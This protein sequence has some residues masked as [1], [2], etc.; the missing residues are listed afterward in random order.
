MICSYI[1]CFIIFFLAL[2]FENEVAAKVH[3]QL[4]SVVVFLNLAYNQPEAMRT[5][6]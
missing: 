2:K 5:Q 3:Y 1:H 4:A 6:D